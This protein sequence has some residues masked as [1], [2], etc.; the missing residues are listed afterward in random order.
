MVSEI[1]DRLGRVVE[2]EPA[3]DHQPSQAV[4]VLTFLPPGFALYALHVVIRR[5]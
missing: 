3:L 4:P 5:A 2:A 1:G